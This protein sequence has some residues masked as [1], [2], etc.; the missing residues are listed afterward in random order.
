L[1]VVWPGGAL[2]VMAHG[3]ARDGGCPAWAVLGWFAG[4]VGQDR[5]VGVGGQ[6]DAGMAEHVLHDF[7]VGSGRQRE[8]GGA[9]PQVVQP[10]RRLNFNYLRISRRHTLNGTPFRDNGASA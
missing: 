3:P 10:D 9:V 8:R 7:Q 2:R 1:A 6:H 4:E 5:G